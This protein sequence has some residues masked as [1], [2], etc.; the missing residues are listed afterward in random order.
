MTLRIGSVY[1]GILAIDYMS[2]A[3]VVYWARRTYPMARKKTHHST[4]AALL[5]LD[6]SATLGRVAHG[7][8]LHASY[9]SYIF[10]GK[11]MP[12]LATAA[13]IASYLGV[14]TDRLYVVLQG[15]K[16]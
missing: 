8:G 12:S 5:L 6:N 11:R 15:I 9:V 7:T 14:S 2:L 10:N 1:A 13:R 3:G 4:P 16:K